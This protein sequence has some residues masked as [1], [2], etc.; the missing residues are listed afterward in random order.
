M[1]HGEYRPHGLMCT[2]YSLRRDGGAAGDVNVTSVCLADCQS[3]L[4]KA[5]VLFIQSR[6]CHAYS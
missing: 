3:A 4:R 5:L 2:G 1:G 6:P